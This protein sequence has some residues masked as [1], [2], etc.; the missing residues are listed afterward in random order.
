MNEA[1]GLTFDE[2]LARAA[3]KAQRLVST[4]NRL[5]WL[6]PFRKV[7]AADAALRAQRELIR[8]LQRQAS[9]GD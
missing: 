3:Q 4:Y 9:R 5:T 8:M 7:A 2:L 1:R 6:T